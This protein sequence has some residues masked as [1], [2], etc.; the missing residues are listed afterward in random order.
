MNLN[1]TN[2]KD[3]EYICEVAL[4]YGAFDAEDFQRIAKYRHQE[5]K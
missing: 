1:L 5:V 3:L 4:G 2:L